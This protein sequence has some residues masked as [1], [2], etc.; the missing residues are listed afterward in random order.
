MCILVTDIWTRVT[1]LQAGGRLT[2]ARPHGPI[3]Q[4][5]LLT[6]RCVPPTCTLGGH[7][8]L[9]QEHWSWECEHAGSTRS[10]TR[11]ARSRWSTSRRMRYAV[12]QSSRDQDGKA[13]RSTYLCTAASTAATA[14]APATAGDT[15]RQVS[16]FA[17]SLHVASHTT[18]LRPRQPG[19]FNA[20]TFIKYGT[21]CDDYVL[22]ICL[23]VPSHICSAI[24]LL[25]RVNFYYTSQDIV[26]FVVIGYSS[27]ID[28]STEILLIMTNDKVV[29]NKGTYDSQGGP[30]R[31]PP[32]PYLPP[33]LLRPP[34]LPQ[35][36]AVH[37]HHHP[38]V[39][40]I[41]LYYLFIIWM[42]DLLTR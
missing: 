24:F 25:L 6:R 1:A 21:L 23:V 11:Q 7:C 37:P 2:R 27:F 36:Q 22:A 38:Q 19:E 15:F 12:T 10:H 3:R 32:P 17:T 4:W 18:R 31:T 20:G 16:T 8:L 29:E 13:M 35:H 28:V 5:D 42:M 34:H 9:Y 40:N 41:S 39:G 33:P 26:Q 14:P 30:R